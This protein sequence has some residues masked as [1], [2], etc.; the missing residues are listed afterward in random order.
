MLKKE[1]P[2]P[3][4]WLINDGKFLHSQFAD[5]HEELHIRHKDERK[6]IG[7]GEWYWSKAT[8][9][10]YFFGKSPYGK[11]DRETFE[12]TLAEN[13]IYPRCFNNAI[14]CFSA[15]LTLEEAVADCTN[16]RIDEASKNEA[17]Y[18]EL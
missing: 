11:I 16:R 17:I 14:I 4:L 18:V 2:N 13:P 8:N 15:E 6:T 5:T 9:T 12:K 1:L 3:Q 7:G 10:V